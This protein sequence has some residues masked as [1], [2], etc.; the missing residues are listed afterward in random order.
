MLMDFTELISGLTKSFNS[1]YFVENVL[2]LPVPKI[3]PQGRDAILFGRIVTSTT[4]P[5][6]SLHEYQ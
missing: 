3:S 1:E 5:I 2:T 6:R 4:A